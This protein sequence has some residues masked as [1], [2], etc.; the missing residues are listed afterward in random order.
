MNLNEIRKE[1]PILEDKVYMNSCSLGALSK[2]SR[3]YVIDYLD[4]WDKM[5]ASA[6][7]EKWMGAIGE[8]KSMFAA[9]LGADESEIALGQHISG[10][11]SS[12]GSCCDFKDRNGIVITDM[13]FPTSNYQW[14]AKKDLGADVSIIESDDRIYIPESEFERTIDNNTAIVSTSHVFFLSG[15]IQDIA[16]I[17]AYA[18]DKSAL[19]VIDAYQSVG[20]VPVNVKEMNIDVLLGGGLKWLLGGSGITFMYI[21][22]ELIKSLK[23]T[24]TGWFGVKD[25]FNFGQTDFTYHDDARRF[26][27]GTPPVAAVVAAKGGLELVLE[28]GL[29]NIWKMTKEITE[30]LIHHLKKAGIKLRIPE[31]SSERSAIVMAVHPDPAP[32]V[33]AL[34]ERN[35]IVDYRKDCIRIS[36][37][38]YNNSEDVEN[39]VKNLKELI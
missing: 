9:V 18:R 7:Y 8:V 4:L 19:C 23:P 11:L 26:E 27:T 32:V 1:F 36:P 5:G 28:I 39:F 2:R 16:K 35:I 33:R 13:D 34:A 10:L 21:K 20:Q 22:K 14:L 12:L 24:I 17:N 30:E 31:S 37:Y 15:Y 29:E 3:Q 25:Q 6:W 38:F